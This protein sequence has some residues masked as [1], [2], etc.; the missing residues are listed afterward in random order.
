MQNTS[1]NLKA[2]SFV[3]RFF[4]RIFWHKFLSDQ[5]HTDCDRL[6]NALRRFLTTLFGLW[7]RFGSTTDADMYL[8]LLG[9][10]SPTEFAMDTSDSPP[11]PT[12][13]A[14]LTKRTAT[15]EEVD[16]RS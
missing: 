10:M 13:L 3:F 14:N 5:R 6:K 7:F 9:L 2:F 15:F 11:R 16:I 4:W 1:S 12:R 8:K